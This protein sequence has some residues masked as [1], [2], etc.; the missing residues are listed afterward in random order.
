MWM[1]LWAV[2]QIRYSWSL[3][4]RA[5]L[6]AQ[7]I[8]TSSQI[9]VG[10]PILRDA[11]GQESSEGRNTSDTAQENY[12]LTVKILQ[13]RLQSVLTLL[14]VLQRD[15]RVKERVLRQSVQALTEEVS[16]R[17]HILTQTEQRRV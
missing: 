17:E 16:G 10:Q 14:Q 15:V 12:L 8:N 7:W 5:L 3:E 1:T 13:A 11:H 9:S 6:W 4:A 2:E